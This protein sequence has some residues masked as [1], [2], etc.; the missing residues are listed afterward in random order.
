MPAA[1]CERAARF[2][3]SRVAVEVALIEELRAQAARRVSERAARPGMSE[4]RLL[5]ARRRA[6]RAAAQRLVAGCDAG[7]REHVIPCAQDVRDSD[8]GMG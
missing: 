6:E 1:A 4:R 7:E 5:A 8:S 3:E 2:L